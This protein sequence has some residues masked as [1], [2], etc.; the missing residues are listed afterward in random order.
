MLT[1]DL[2]VT[3]T[4]KGKIEPVYAILDQDNLEIARSVIDVFEEHV[5]KT[6]GDL[7]DELDGIEEINFRL[8]RGLAQIL[9]R[10]C[11]IDADSVIDPA[12]ARRAVFEESKGFV[13]DCEERRLVLDEVARKLSIEPDDLEIALWA[14]HEG[15]L[16]VKEFKPL[17][18][19]DLLRQY[20]LSLVQLSY[21]ELHPW[22]SR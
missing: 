16:V 12:A 4:S 22:R 9:E 17:A 7:F 6:Y 3:R 1:S 18:P 15:N 8:I 10:R 13:A 20:N 5:G 14:D 19:D 2:L 21:S 11:T